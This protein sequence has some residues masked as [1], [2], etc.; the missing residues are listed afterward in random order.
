MSPAPEEDF[1]SD[2]PSLDE[3]ASLGRD[4]FVAGYFDE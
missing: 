1:E 3:I 2:T 4:K